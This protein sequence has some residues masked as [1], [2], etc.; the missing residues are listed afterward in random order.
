VIGDDYIKACFSQVYGRIATES[1]AGAGYERGL[2]L[3]FSF[4]F[5]GVYILRMSCMTMR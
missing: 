4:I 1:S 2:S 5:H 3:Q